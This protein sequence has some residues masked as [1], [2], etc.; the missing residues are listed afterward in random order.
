[1]MTTQTMTYEVTQGSKYNADLDVA[2]VAKLVRQ[3]LKAALPRGV[4][5]TVR[6]HRY[7]GGQSLNVAIVAFPG[8]VLNPAHVFAGE[9]EVYEESTR[10]IYS[11]GV[12]AALATIGEVL[13]S[14]QRI[15]AHWQ[16]DYNYMSTNFYTH[17]TVRIDT[18]AERAA[19]LAGDELADLKVAKAGGVKGDDLAALIRAYTL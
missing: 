3:D 1:M 16:S 15:E 6:I 4:K 11:A 8:P 5:T 17:G 13:G 14:Y 10:E 19:L 2:Q 7:A 12:R 9:L 18:T